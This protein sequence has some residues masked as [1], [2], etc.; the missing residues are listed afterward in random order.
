MAEC[1]DFPPKDRAILT[2]IGVIPD[3][4][5]FGVV[6][7]IAASWLRLGQTNYYER[8]HH[9]LFHGLVSS[10]A[11]SALAAMLAKNRLKTFLWTLV[12]IHFHLI[13]DLVGSRGPTVYDIWP[14]YYLSLFSQALTISW[15][16]QWPLWAWPNVLFSMGLI[17][18]VFIRTI[19]HG[20]SPLSLVSDRMNH[21][22]VKTVQARW[23]G[24]TQKHTDATKRFRS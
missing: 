24:K 6:I 18:F 4:D 9:I 22:F 8:F 16:H 23:N 12:V 3:V 10:I 14:V 17:L 2:W 11:F 13:C 7:D 5:A 20:R 1:L 15:S 21:T 19:S